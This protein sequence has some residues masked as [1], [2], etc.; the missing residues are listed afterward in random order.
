MKT[1]LDQLT[2]AEFI[3]MLCGYSEVVREEGDTFTEDEVAANVGSLVSK[4]KQ[5]VDPSGSKSVI[6]R[7]ARVGRRSM[8][9]MFLR[10]CSALLR[11]GDK[12]KV[13]EML[14]EFGWSV[15]GK[16]ADYVIRKCQREYKRLE[17]EEKRE[18]EKL[19]AGMKEIT[20]DDSEDAIRARFSAEVA[21][22]ITYYKMPINF[23]EITA[24][25][26]ANIVARAYRESRERSAKAKKK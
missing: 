7:E 11:V 4:Y 13:Y 21:D 2:M 3:E 19:S 15:K 26:Y 17:A 24:D 8:K 25:V 9:I 14:V 23:R 1:R 5:V 10:L 18:A 6:V 20:Q 12:E 16:S 22:I